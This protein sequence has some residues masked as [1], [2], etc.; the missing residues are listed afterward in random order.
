MQPC[1]KSWKGPHAGWMPIPLFF[2][3]RP[4]PLS[5]YCSTHVSHRCVY[6]NR[7]LSHGHKWHAQINLVKIGR[8]PEICSRTDTQQIR[9]PT[10][11]SQCSAFLPGQSNEA[12]MQ[13]RPRCAARRL[14]E[15]CQCHAPGEVPR[16]CEH[17]ASFTI[18]TPPKVGLYGE[19]M[20][21]R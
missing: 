10:C 9:K 5:R 14:H 16:Y 11:S 6:S 12:V 17:L 19:L 8:V 7:E 18:I 13:N 21:C 4:F 3:L 15:Y 1:L 20:Q 2:I